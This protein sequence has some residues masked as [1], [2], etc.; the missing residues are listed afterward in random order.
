MVMVITP[1]CRHRFGYS[2][3]WGARCYQ[4]A[5]GVVDLRYLP[6]HFSGGRF[7]ERTE[8]ETNHEISWFASLHTKW[9]SV[10]L[11]LVISLRHF[12]ALL[13]LV[14]SALLLLVAPAFL[15]VVHPPDS[16]AVDIRENEPRHSPLSRRVARRRHYF[17]MS[18]RPGGRVR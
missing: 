10:L 11:L 7:S 13:L 16:P 2:L 3:S 1:R 12:S 18:F 15:V 9:V 6:L 8:D 5:A 17:G 4:W 14:I